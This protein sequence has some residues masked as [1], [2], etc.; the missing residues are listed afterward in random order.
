MT[1]HAD[2][3]VIGTG[4]VGSAALYHL[5]RRGVRVL[6]IDRFPGGHDRG[7][8][9]G[10]SRII[11]LAY[12]EHPDYVPLLRCAYD[13]WAQLE[14]LQGEQLFLQT[15]LLEIGA[16]D[17]P[18]IQGIRT[19]ARQHQLAVDEMSPAACRRRFPGFIVPDDTATIFEKQAGVLR[20]ER[21]VL[22]HLDQAQRRGASLVV[23]EAV[24]GWKAESGGV[25][26]TTDK[27]VYRAGKLIITLGAW[28]SGFLA[29]PLQVRRKHIHWYPSPA[30]L[31]AADRGC[32]A[33]YFET[34][35][36][37]FY[38]IPAF[39]GHGL[40]V[41]EHSGGAAVTDP[42]TDARGVDAEDRRRVEAFLESYL[43]DVSR[44]ALDHCTCFYTMSPDSQF[45][46]DRHPEHANVAFAA[47]LSGHGFKFTCVLGEALADLAL[48]GRTDLPIRFL[49]A[50]RLG[51][52]QGNAEND[53][54]SSY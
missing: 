15:G 3:I 48:D 6:G 36:G 22:A 29:L 31:Y 33:Y 54:I 13:L 39:D 44:P 43:P 16:S 9:H 37:D 45:L 51:K 49:S 5:A 2:V 17:G 53:K 12:F 26:I 40:K 23:G 27:A 21:C 35:A 19:A 7:S 20:V 11:R 46:V 24:Q 28:A 47:G 30:E 8:S 32:P 1:N 41:G 10:H 14:Q 38:G 42:L 25:E 18:T 4:G 50:A 52:R 34:P